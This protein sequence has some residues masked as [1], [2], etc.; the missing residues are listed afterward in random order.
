MMHHKSWPTTKLMHHLV[1][2][3]I[4]APWCT[5]GG[6]FHKRDFNRFVLQELL[7]VWSFLVYV[8]EEEFGDSNSVLCFV[9]ILKHCFSLNNV[10]CFP[11]HEFA[12]VGNVFFHSFVVLIYVPQRKPSSSSNLPPALANCAAKFTYNPQQPKLR[13]SY[14]ELAR[15]PMSF[16]Y[17]VKF[18]HTM[19]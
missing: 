3:L 10:F 19:H 17:I 14:F 15:T 12:K 9:A 16:W 11:A 1:H 8:H 7:Q 13:P 6:K 2:Q 5:Q 18:P 4:D